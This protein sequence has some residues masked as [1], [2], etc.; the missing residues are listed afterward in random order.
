MTPLSNIGQ[1]FYWA[2]FI[3]LTLFLL[4]IA[5]HP[6]MVRTGWRVLTGHLG[7]RYEDESISVMGFITGYL[8]GIGT[9]AITGIGALMALMPSLQTTGSKMVLITLFVLLADI[10]RSVTVLYI[11]TTFNWKINLQT[12][13]RAYL[14]FRGLV[15]MVLYALLLLMPLLSSQVNVVLLSIVAIAYLLLMGWK[16]TTVFPICWTNIAYLI[17][18]FVHLEILPAVIVLAGAYKI[19]V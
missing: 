9:F 12:L 17:L 4:T 10:A 2:E 6:N 14:D 8:F 7:R 11:N 15:C 5:V 19:L 3:L 18:Y 13:C 16:L 1:S